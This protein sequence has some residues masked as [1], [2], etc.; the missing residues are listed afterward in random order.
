MTNREAFCKRV[1]E[2]TLRADEKLTLTFPPK[3]CGKWMVL[4]NENHLSVLMPIQDVLEFLSGERGYIED[5]ERYKMG[6]NKIK[7][8]WE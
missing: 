5:L 8:E 1:F 6:I 3:H 2:E 7:E 4:S